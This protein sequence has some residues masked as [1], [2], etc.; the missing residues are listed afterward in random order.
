MQDRRQWC[1]W[2][3]DIQMFMDRRILSWVLHFFCSNESLKGR[4]FLLEWAILELDDDLFCFNHTETEARRGG[5]RS[6]GFP[7]LLIPFLT[8]LGDLRPLLGGRGN[9]P[10]EDALFPAP[11]TEVRAL[12]L[13]CHQLGSFGRDDPLLEL[14]VC[15]KHWPYH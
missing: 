10:L 4:S 7:V 8:V 6:C 2:K 15:G 1:L 3:C 14:L 12:R 11:K 9:L 5:S 13:D